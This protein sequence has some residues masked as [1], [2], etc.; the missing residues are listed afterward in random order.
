M[1]PI[2]LLDFGGWQFE[3]QPLGA[4]LVCYFKKSQQMSLNNHLFFIY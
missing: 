3:A 2:F 4:Q 1:G